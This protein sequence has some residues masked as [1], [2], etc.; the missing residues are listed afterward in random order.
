MTQEEYKKK[1]QQTFDFLV[2]RLTPKMKG[3]T[4]AE[5]QDRAIAKIKEGCEIFDIDVESFLGNKT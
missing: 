2:K 1:Q 3:K 4:L 5:K